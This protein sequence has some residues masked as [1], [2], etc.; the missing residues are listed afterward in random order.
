M[1]DPLIP[2]AHLFGNPSRAQA[3]ISPDGQR[4]SFLA[5]VEGVLN[6]WV[7]PIDRWQE[8]RPVTRDAARGI[9][10]HAWAEN[11]THLLYMQDRGGDEN[12]R[13]YSVE[14]A[15]GTELDLSPFEGVAAR[16]VQ[17]SPDFPDEVLLA[18][19]HR[20]PQYHDVYRVNVV[21]G[22]RAL[23]FQ[24]ERFAV[25]LGGRDL[26]VH[27]AL[28][29]TPDGGLVV[30]RREGADWVSAFEVSKEDAL[31]TGPLLVDERRGVVW[32]QDSRG[33]DT[34]ALV[35]W[36]LRTDTREVI[37][38]SERA[39]VSGLLVHPQTREV[40]AWSE[41]WDR[42]R[43][44]AI[45]PSIAATLAHLRGLGEGDLE[46]V[47]RDRADAQWILAWTRDDGPV[48]YARFDR[49]TQR[50]HPL[51]SSRPE[52]D[53][54]PLTRMHPRILRARDGLSLVSYLSLPRGADPS[55][56]G[57]PSTPLP[58]V[59]VVHGGP[60]ARDELGFHP[61]HQWLANR[62]Y[63]VLSVN[64]RGS[65]GF[66]KAFIGAADGQWGAAMH[67]DLL[68]AVAWA[69]EAGVAD[70]A[71]VA[72]FGG[73]Y[74]GYATL[75]GLTFTPEVFACGVD[76]VGPSNLETL[77]ETIPPYWK[78][79]F[80]TMAQRVGDPRTEEGLA[81]LRARSP[82][83]RVDA[84]RKPLLIA[85]GANDPRVKQSE[86]DQIVAAMR[87]KGLPVTYVLF[88]DEGHGFARPENNQAFFAVA[89]AFLAPVLGGRFEPIGDDLHGS[90]IEVP[91]GAAH[92]PGLSAALGD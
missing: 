44:H 69:V 87:A 19:N 86:S 29:Q 35:R 26:D 43:W 27:L 83:H 16:V 11:S 13:I 65:T 18:L 78:P 85:Q 22:A 4:I 68:D 70:P 49:T 56:D 8:A 39:D 55:G 12:W 79:M 31:T 38:E 72:V 17:S 71:R 37:G 7:G 1:N 81:L 5:P 62:G 77:L 36:D 33:R 67:D 48:T 80:E 91:E 63:A 20:D 47:D 64:F 45:D 88:P 24:N 52:L 25:V 61:Y 41:T 32:L 53:G 14:T 50:L 15:T 59:L 51:F 66:G 21:T 9:R 76:I 54:A 75:V 2:R 34:A 42:V 90:S 23:V 92:V 73:S 3:R 58:L 89:E 46:V 10:F 30:S 57:V 84:I 40:E 28:E 82:L 74:G 6:V 60:W